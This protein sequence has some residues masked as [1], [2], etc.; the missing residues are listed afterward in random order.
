MR[1][2]LLTSTLTI[3]IATVALFGIPLGFVLDRVVHEDAQSR[4]DRDATRVSE[5]LAKDNLVA[6]PGD[7][8]TAALKHVVPSDD[9]VVVHYPSG[10]TV[11][12]GDPVTNSMVA[13][14]EGPQNTTVNISQPVDDVDNLVT[15][16]LFLLVLAAVVAL[17]GALALALVQ[18]SRLS[19]PLARLARS[20]TRLG[21]GDFSL[22]NPRTGLAEIDEIGAALDRSAAS[23][24]QLLR[25]ERSFS[26]HA[27][28]QLRS[29]LTGIQLR[30]E[31][32]SASDNPEVRAEADAAFEQASRL[33]GMIDEL[34]ALARTGRAGI[35]TGFDLSDLVRQHANDV[36]PVLARDGRRVMV[37][38]N[39]AVP[40]VAAVGA[41]GQVLDILLS[42]ATRHGRGNVKV[43][44]STDGQRARVDI[45]DEGNGIAPDDIDT[46]FKAH[47]RPDG[48][49]IGLSLAR[50]LVTTE[51]GTLSLARPRPPVFRVEL[52]LA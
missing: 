45:E 14:S 22:A 35:V 29:A 48:H 25:A 12:V 8:V 44:V 42:N 24:D 33:N 16:A 13:S 9:Y 15:R 28:H 17:G 26:S 3:V 21:E 23:I 36:Q 39:G 20:A 47:E 41:V 37:E 30:L 11:I 6:Q 1:R 18:S 46:L 38:T 4:L 10:R 2:R 51:G 7:E 19:A 49:G 40:V 34:L 52:P 5:E 50:T 43:C 27:S 31:E 32:L